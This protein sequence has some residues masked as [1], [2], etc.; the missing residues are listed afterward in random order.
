MRNSQSVTNRQINFPKERYLISKT[1]LKGVVTFV[2]DEFSRITGFSREDMIG[3]NHHVVRHP[4][5]PAQVFEHLW[6][7]I[8]RGEPWRGV[9]KNRTKNGDYYW[10]DEFIAP[11]KENGAIIGYM[12]VGSEPSSKQIAA[13]EALYKQLKQSDSPFPSPV[14]H[15][16]GLMSRFMIATIT[17]CVLLLI[18]GL[19]GLR[20]IQTSNKNMSDVRT[21]QFEPALALQETLLLMDDAYK[22]AA[23]GAEH[24]PSNSL[25]KFHDHPI[26]EH[27]NAILNS[28]QRI[29]ALRTAIDQHPHDA[30]NKPLLDAFNE[31]TET[32]IESG[33]KPIA[34]N[35]KDREYDNIAFLSSVH[36]APLYAE[37]SS[38]AKVLLQ[39]ILDEA[40]AKKQHSQQTYQQAIAIILAT[41]IGGLLLLIFIS[42]MQALKI[43]R[44]MEQTMREFDFIAEGVMTRQIDIH[45]TNEFGRV[46]K[47][48][49]IMQTNI[50]I[51]LDSIR[52]A[53]IV[54]MQK[55]ADL[56]AQM[57]I[58]L[59]TSRAQQTQ[60][61]N[62]A[63]NTEQFSQS[64]SNVADK[65]NETAHIATDSQHLVE[66]CNNTMSQSMDANAKVVATVNNSSDIITE[67]NQSIQRIGDVT[68]TIRTIADQTNLLA[69][70][71][72]I[73]A[74]RAGEAGRGFAVVADEVRK[75]SEHT[76][77]STT[78]I[79]ALVAEIHRIAESAVRAM[80]DA[81]TEV[82]AGVGKMRES[83]IGLTQITAAS[84]EVTN[85]ALEISNEASEQAAAGVEVSAGM[86]Q[87]AQAV[88]RNVS[89]AKQA[90]DL[91]RDLLD[92]AATM[93]TLM[94]GF[95]LFQYSA[96]EKAAMQ[97][98][99][100][101]GSSELF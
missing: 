8:K 97:K 95:E 52:E 6:Q 56:D 31:T 80:Q 40:E 28:I 49:A 27:T 34:S 84:T 35:L 89:I 5:M 42:R 72:A 20:G 10:A 44:Q 1:D 7:T 68:T 53:V 41:G 32:F 96:E 59:M 12:A 46:N 45:N 66:A 19:I 75:L 100:A 9:M 94:N 11:D 70:N 91:S 61:E 71:A 55:S 14:H 13:A 48:L 73:E 85:M 65:A 98:I 60:V 36:L 62:M 18:T 54:L 64:V 63:A 76:A 21:E 79:T 67:L 47:S 77:N 25:S 99:S 38:N 90:S 69:L 87:V 92:V 39:H 86:V 74:A 50:K 16:L 23:L 88:E 37:A 2:N 58:V 78:D 93:R 83:V 51:M 30:E 81:V 29:I 17:A 82:D 57:H 43:A 22:H 3:K 33:L 4:D 24:N 101:S 15:S 26:D